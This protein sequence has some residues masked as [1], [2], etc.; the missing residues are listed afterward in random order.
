MSLQKRHPVKP[1]VKRAVKVSRPL[2]ASPDSVKFCVVHTM[3]P[4]NFVTENL[5]W[6]CPEPGCRYAELHEA[7]NEAGVPTMGQGPVE[8]F[9]HTD[10]DGD[11]SYYLR[12]PVNG[13]YI[14]LGAVL[15]DLTANSDDGGRVEV[16][17]R[18]P[19]TAITD[20]QKRGRNG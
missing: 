9:M 18:V 5:T 7:A 16:T 11:T 3:Q 12:T 20:P 17:I 1:V 14:P 19:I 8:L 4:L 15:D 2:S 13:V 10:E 6:Q